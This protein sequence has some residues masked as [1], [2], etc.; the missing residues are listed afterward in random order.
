VQDDI[1]AVTLTT[2]D[3]LSL[4]AE[5]ARPD[6][7]DP[8]LRGAVVLA[9]PHPQQGGSM[10][11]LVTSELFGALPGRGLAVLR[12]NFRGVGASEG[13]YGN[14]VDEHADVVAALDALAPEA[15]AA[16]AAGGAGTAG[17]VPLVLAG[18]SFGA[19][20]SL[21]V[22]DERLAGWY[23]IASP[24]RILPTEAFVAAHDPRPK[25]F[26]IPER[27]QF[28]SPDAVREMTADWANVEVNA[29]PGADHFLVGRTKVAV[30]HLDAFVE[31][32]GGKTAA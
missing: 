15:A 5:V 30:D 10:R 1:E 20:V 19:D 17:R 21:T 11:S 27:D 13:S 29:V 7:A 9:H 24:L 2:A 3:G 18:W 8:A 16:R 4:E 25:R 22:L 28:R 23:L 14:G 12:F 32:L 31:Y 26:S 6:A